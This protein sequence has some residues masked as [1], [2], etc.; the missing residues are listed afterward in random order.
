MNRENLNTCKHEWRFQ[1]K[2]DVEINEFEYYYCIYCLAE[3]K[4][5]VNTREKSE[6]YGDYIGEIKEVK[7]ITKW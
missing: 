7:K 2:S 4:R 3:F 1:Y 6:N 5:F